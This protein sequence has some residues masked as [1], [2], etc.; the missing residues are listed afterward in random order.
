[1]IEDSIQ[2]HWDRHLFA[3]CPHTATAVHALAQHR[4]HNQPDGA[5]WAIAATAHPAKFESIVE[6]LVGADVPPPP[7]LAALLTRPAHAE[8]M[9]PT[10]DGLV[11]ALGSI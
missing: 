3:I 9:P 11:A 4:A 8:P 6:P 1:M 7:A 10:Y 2:S 5:T